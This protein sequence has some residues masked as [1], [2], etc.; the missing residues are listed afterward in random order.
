M[1]IITTLP[2]ALIGV[3]SIVALQIRPESI[4]DSDQDLARRQMDTPSSS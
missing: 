2:P 3:G 1:R 4:V